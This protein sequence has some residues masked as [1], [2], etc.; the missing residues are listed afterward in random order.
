LSGGAGGSAGEQEP[1]D[2]QLQADQQV[3]PQGREP[4]RPFGFPLGRQR[5]GAEPKLRVRAWVRAQARQGTTTANQAQDPDDD[6]HRPHG[7][8]DTTATVE[9]ASPPAGDK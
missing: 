6:R 2:D 7:G 1:A 4:D 5:T 8:S 9:R 3:K